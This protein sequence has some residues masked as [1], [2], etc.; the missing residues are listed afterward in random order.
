[1]SNS[2]KKSKSS[3]TAAICMGFHPEGEDKR[4]WLLTLTIACKI[5]GKLRCSFQ[6]RHVVGMPFCRIV[7]RGVF[8]E[9]KFVE[10]HSST[11]LLSNAHAAQWLQ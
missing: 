2:A 9:P 6:G 11:H 4:N 3:R 1:M 5:G 8:I 7:E 10:R